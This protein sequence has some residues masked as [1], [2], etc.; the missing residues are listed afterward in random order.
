MRDATLLS[1]LKCRDPEALEQL[2]GQYQSYVCTIISSMLQGIGTYSDTE[3]LCS[4]TFL[5]VWQHADAI[6]PG[7]LKAYL[8]TAARN[9][10]KTWLRARREMPMDLDT[11]E[12]PDDSLPLEEQA[13]RDEL[14]ARV[15]EAV[16]SMRPRDREIFLRYYFYMQSAETI[17]SALGIPAGTVRSRLTRGKAQLRI[18]LSKE[19][20]S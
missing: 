7:K 19:G 1:R 9:K 6:E 5:S 20:L 13:I 8:G 17:S 18:I 4:D 2:S 16:A 10:A 11:V 3:E 15:R 12:I 14:A